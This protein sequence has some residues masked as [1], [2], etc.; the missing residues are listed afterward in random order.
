MSEQPLQGIGYLPDLADFRDFSKADVPEIMN[1]INLQAAD[2]EIPTKNDFSNLF[3]P[4]RNQGSLGSC[5]AYASAG[6]IVEYYNKNIHGD[7][8]P[9]STLFQYKLTRDLMGVTGDTG[10][11]MRTAMEALIEYGSVFEKD[12]P[13]DVKKF[14]LDPSINIK[15]KAQNRQA[16]SYVRVDQR[17]VSTTDVLKELRRY[18]SSNLPIMFGFS[19]YDN[20]W[21]QANS[22][23]SEGA[24]PFPSKTDK[25]VGGHAIC[26]AGFDDTKVV[27]NKQDGARTIGAFKIRNS[28]GDKWGVK[29]YGWIPYKYVESQ[30]AMDFWLLTSMEWIDSKVTQK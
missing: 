5:T 14:D 28:W 11:F 10:A 23:G 22:S 19:V 2:T 9:M 29:G 25:M 20:S 1:K 8:T 3:T 18:A 15:L 4:V 13:Y 26:I 16:L 6:G 27:T 21:K 7:S 17:N 24:F 30:L 12:Y